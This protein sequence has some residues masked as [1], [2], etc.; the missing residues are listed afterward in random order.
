MTDA[1]HVSHAASD[2]DNQPLVTIAEQNQPEIR[3]LLALS[4]AHLP[5]D[6]GTN[7]LDS[8]PGVIAYPTMYGWLLWVPTTRTSPQ[9]R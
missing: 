3:S 8:E 9:P 2:R 1:N 5:A 6:L 4:T 7:G